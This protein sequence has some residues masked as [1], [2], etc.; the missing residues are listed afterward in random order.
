MITV[1]IVN[2]NSSEFVNLSLHA[3]TALTKNPFKVHI[4]D[5]G[6]RMDDYSRLEKFTS[7]YNNVFIERW[8]TDLRGSMAHGTALN[9]L[10]GKV[11]T[12]YFV[13]LDADAT[14]LKK[15]WDEILIKR[16]DNEIKAIGTQAP[17]EKPQ[18]FP[19]MFAILFET[20]AFKSLNI[21]FRPK[22]LE[23][24]Q[25]TG[26]DMRDKYFDAG[27]KGENIEMRNTR[28]YKE[29]PFSKIISAEYYL[30]G[31]GHIFASH[32]G[33]GSS[34]GKAKYGKGLAGL[35]Y[36]IPLIGESV[37]KLKGKRE[38]ME[39]IRICKKVIDKQ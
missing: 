17:P 16:F 27:F 22:D 30:E 21:D 24:R 29:G 39:W 18:D 20:D 2:F 1:L 34:L 28:H 19:L 4:V 6:S 38:K 33:R 35:F 7:K 37:I 15:G 14:W 32:F 11:D 3:L 8:D 25:D 10:V 9:H 12:P 23:A 31:E 13:I 36:K 26:H 5:N